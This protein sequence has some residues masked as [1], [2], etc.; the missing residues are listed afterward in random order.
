MSTGLVGRVSGMGRSTTFTEEVAAKICDLI[1]EG[2]PLRQICRD[3]AMPAWR[4]VYDWIDAHPVFAARF[5]QARDMGY[6]MIAEEAL[7]IAD[8]TEEG[9]TT[10]DM[11]WGQQET[12]GDM[13]DHRKLRVETRLKLLAKWSPKKYGDKQEITHKVD[14]DTTARLLSGRQRTG[15]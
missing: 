8:T 10:K 7:E 11:E 15:G 13:L 14:D 12:R 2:T 6:D 3:E 5:A 1:A 9:V 4:T